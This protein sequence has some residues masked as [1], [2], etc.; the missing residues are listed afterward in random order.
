MEKG[1][2]VLWIG[3]DERQLVAANT[4][5]DMG[6]N[7][8]PRQMELFESPAPAAPAPPTSFSVTQLPEETNSIMAAIQSGHDTL[9]ALCTALGLAP[10]IL[11]PQLMRLQVMRRI[12]PLPGSRY[13]VV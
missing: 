9:D 6:W 13:Q 2:G 4:M 1:I 7:A 3:G 5:Q 11:T 8:P 10:H 12:A